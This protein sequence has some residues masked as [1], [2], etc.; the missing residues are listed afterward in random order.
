MLTG[1]EHMLTSLY[2]KI[3]LHKATSIAHTQLDTRGYLKVASSC[4]AT[5]PQATLIDWRLGGLHAMLAVRDISF[6]F[7][8]TDR[9]C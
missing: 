6:T 2:I 5:V 8:L 3:N 7:I 1:G 9:L 4:W